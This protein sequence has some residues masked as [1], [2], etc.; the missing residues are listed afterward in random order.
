MN[1]VK[2][3]VKEK[4][5]NLS[6][7][8]QLIVAMVGIAV[9]LLLVLGSL[10]Y[11]ISR[12]TLEQN[13]RETHAYN[14]ELF[15]SSIR[16]RLEDIVDAS[17]GLLEH[18]SYVH[19]MKYDSG[20]GAYFSTAGQSQ[21]EKIF[22]NIEDGNDN[23]RGVLAISASGKF[24]YVKKYS[25][26]PDKVSDFYKSGDILQQDWI[27]VADSARG[28]EVF[29]G[30]NVLDETD[31]TLFSMVKR[32]NE[33]GS[34]KLLGYVVINISK[35]MIDKTFGT[36]TDHFESNR[37]LIFDFSPEKCRDQ[38]E[39]QV[40]YYN[41]EE[42]DLEKIMAACEV[43]TEQ[44]K[45]LFSSYYEDMSGWEI[46]SVIDKRELAD[47]SS[48]IRWTMLLGIVLLT[49]ISIPAANFLT[50]QINSPLELLEETIH[51][52]GQGN[53]KPGVVF[54]N[55]EI[56]IVGQ[57][58]IDITA[59]NLELRERLLQSEIKE[60]EAELLLLQSQINPHFLYNTLDAL[61][62]MAVI[63]RADDIAE[64]V[65]SL[66]D[67]FKLSL[68][69]GDKLI[70]VQNELEKI[71]AYM[72]IQNLRYHNRFEFQVDVDEEI[73]KEKI[74]TFILQPVVENA[75]YHG[76]EGKVG[77]GAI[78]LVGYE[79]DGFLRFIIND[80]GIGIDDMAK[81][82]NGYGVKNIRE[83][84]HLFYGEEYDVS[85]ESAQGKGTTVFYRLPKIKGEE[86]CEESGCH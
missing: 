71:H 36:Q 62:F 34:R 82:E 58:F 55:S 47:Q 3:K 86:N 45:Y 13:Y 43:G 20:Q 84:I 30:Y 5:R 33:P 39:V 17:R 56:G 60:R 65:K 16:I 18:A 48:Y 21:I 81:L 23:V 31:D 44:D 29:F 35:S 22:H 15:S 12:H 6:Y 52:V 74:L 53:Y 19:I 85:F 64:M 49:G 9:F 40:V 41:V 61:Y 26:Q 37:Y 63:D 11:G 32:M 42:N 76:L 67:T 80:N 70:T 51:Q 69:K 38:K 27:T 79:E 54:D 66:S 10:L 78:S 68:N 4:I 83:R 2:E 75:V 14:M 46:V 59:N 24:R 73:L 1:G 50:K 25:N 72:K 77:N 8:R 28:K 7:K 57:H